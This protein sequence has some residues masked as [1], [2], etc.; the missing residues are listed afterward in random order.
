MRTHKKESSDN[1]EKGKEFPFDVVH[2]FIVLDKVNIVTG[3]IRMQKAGFAKQI[4]CTITSRR[5][6]NI[7]NEL[8]RKFNQR[9]SIFLY[10]V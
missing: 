8:M 1:I 10:K 2:T 5:D 4:K 6:E 3:I 9:L 7:C